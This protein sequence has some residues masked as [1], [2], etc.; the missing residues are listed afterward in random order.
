MRI[1]GV[2]GISGSGD[3][4][5]E[6][7]QASH[8]TGVALGGTGKL[9]IEM[10]A[11]E[12]LRIEAEDNLLG[13]IETEVRDGRLRIQTQDQINLK[14]KKPIRYYLQVKSLDTIVLSGMGDIKAQDLEANRFAV[15]ISGMGNVEI[16]E[17]NANR[18]DVIIS[19]MGDL[20]IAGGH[21]EQQD[22][23][24]SGVGDFQAGN[25]WSEKVEI[26]TS[27]V[28]NATVW[29]I[30]TLDAQISGSGSVNYYGS[31]R[32]DFSRSGSGAL[33]SL[34]NHKGAE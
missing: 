34:G 1:A 33:N 8:F 16:G 11:E 18:L 13:Y 29:A 9:T 14:P 10:G 25:V 21:V 31:P 3:V 12:S 28:G 20:E 6:K 15:R 22:I 19:G 26:V 5:E 2:S 24:I 30:E 27:G 17:L 4:V 32:V 23:I 7:R